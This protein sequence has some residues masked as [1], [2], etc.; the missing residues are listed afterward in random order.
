MA[1]FS[2]TIK[3]LQQQRHELLDQVA[4]IDRAIAALNGADKPNRTPGL[5]DKPTPARAAAPSRPAGRKRR[6]FTLSEEH[7][8]KLVEGRKRAREARTAPQVAV[9]EPVPAIAGWTGEGSPRLVK[10]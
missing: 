6:G 10:P 8:R 2:A 1:D 9:E 4:A 7:K 3:T 5:T